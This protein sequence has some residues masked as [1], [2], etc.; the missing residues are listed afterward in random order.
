MPSLFSGR[1]SAYEIDDQEDDLKNLKVGDQVESLNDVTVRE[2]EAMSTEKV[3]Y[4]PEGTP[5]VV[6]EFGSDP[7]RIRCEFPTKNG[8]AGWV[9]IFDKK[10]G[11]PLLKRIDQEAH[12]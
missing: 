8:I 1:S 12:E 7:N 4:F 9:S 2:S 5:A 6:M 11:K 3:G 10:L